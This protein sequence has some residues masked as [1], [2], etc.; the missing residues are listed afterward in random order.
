MVQVEQFGTGT[1]HEL[2]ILQQC[3]K[4]VR[5]KSLKVL[6]SNCYVCRSYRGKSGRRAFL[7]PPPPILNRLK[8][9]A[10]N[11]PFDKEIPNE[12]YILQQKK[13]K[14]KLMILN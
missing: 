3:G 4:S 7:A 11:I 9:K 14:K 5:T 10:E 13:I 2:E 8:N 6:G 1:R 12:R